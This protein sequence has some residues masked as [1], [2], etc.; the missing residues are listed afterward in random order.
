MVRVGFHRKP[1]CLTAQSFQYK[2]GE[3]MFNVLWKR[4]SISLYCWLW[5]S[6]YNFYWN[7][8]LHHALKWFENIVSVFQK[9]TIQVQNL[10]E[11]NEQVFFSLENVPKISARKMQIEYH[12]FLFDSRKTTFFKSIIPSFGRTFFHHF[13]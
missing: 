1:L 6:V 10:K 5:Q 3:M 12:F 13:F 4:C 9:N 7:W 8:R 11:R 2:F